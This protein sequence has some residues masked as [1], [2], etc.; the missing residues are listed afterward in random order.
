[1]GDSSE[2]PCSRSLERELSALIVGEYSSRLGLRSLFTADARA[3]VE[4]PFDSSLLNRGGRAHGGAL[5][6]VLLAAVRVAAAA[7]EKE[8]SERHVRILSANVSFL[9][10]PSRG[11]LIA[12][13]RIVRRG[14]EIAHA[15]AEA[16]DERGVCVANAAVTTGFLAAGDDGSRTD[17]GGARAQDLSAAR[18]VAESP[19]LSAA[20]VLILPPEQ[21][22]ARALLPR[23]RNRAAHPGRVDEGAIAGLADSCAAY[24]AHLCDTGVGERG[25][26]TVSMALAFHSSREEDLIGAGVVT[27]RAAGCYLATVDVRG[28]ASGISAASGFAVYRLPA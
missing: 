7:S 12:E 22:V 4:M 19:Y 3:S 20:G 27:G 2:V 6:S 1:M 8:P 10:V 14:R 24:A 28:A 13:A 9:T 26:V 15:V 25:G 17:E 11:R 16:V 18:P 21:R 5:A 23:V